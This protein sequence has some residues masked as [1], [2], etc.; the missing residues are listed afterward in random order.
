MMIRNRV[1]I[2]TE[3]GFTAEDSG[4]SELILLFAILGNAVPSTF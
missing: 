3:H 2:N 1:R 4:R